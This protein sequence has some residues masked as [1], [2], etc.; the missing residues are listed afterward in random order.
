VTSCINLIVLRIK[1]SLRLCIPSLLI[2]ITKLHHQPH[3]FLNLPPPRS[4]SLQYHIN[5]LIPVV[6]GKRR[7]VLLT[8]SGSMSIPYV[9]PSVPGT[10]SQSSYSIRSAASRKPSIYDRNLNR[11]RGLELSHSAFTLLFAE[12]VSYT[13]NKVEGI[14]E[15]E[16]RYVIWNF[17][18]N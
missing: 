12:M 8:S 4:F 14:A 15:L 18:F 9:P 1:P 13:Q 11:T 16:R 6:Y 10:P 17:P 2:A 7:L 5:N 3:V